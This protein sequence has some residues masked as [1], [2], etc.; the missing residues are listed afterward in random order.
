MFHPS[1]VLAV[2]V[3]GALVA[4]ALMQVLHELRRS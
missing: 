2:L 3:I 4:T 1:D